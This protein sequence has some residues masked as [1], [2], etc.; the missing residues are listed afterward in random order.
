LLYPRGDILLAKSADA[1][2]SRSWCSVAFETLR[3]TVRRTLEPVARSELVR[4]KQN[5]QRPKWF[6]ILQEKV[7]LQQV[8][9][10]CR[11]VCCAKSRMR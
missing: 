1:M 11:H 4:K 6:E 7:L 2:L 8:A 9:V 3:L 10:R 5:R